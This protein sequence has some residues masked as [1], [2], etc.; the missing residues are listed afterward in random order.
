MQFS[1]SCYRSV[2]LKY[3]QFA[4]YPTMAE[5]PK[6]P[7]SYLWL[8]NKCLTGINQQKGADLM[9][10]LREISQAKRELV[11]DTMTTVAF[12]LFVIS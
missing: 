9:R 12:F 6:A 10:Q 4:D 11:P 2:V 7:P 5:V 8:K 1:E 3:L